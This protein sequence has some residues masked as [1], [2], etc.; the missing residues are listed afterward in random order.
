MVYNAPEVSSGD[1]SLL[2][3]GRQAGAGPHHIQG[4]FY[5]MSTVKITRTLIVMTLLAT[6]FITSVAAE[7]PGPPASGRR[8]VDTARLIGRLQ[9]ETED[10]ARIS[11]HGE[12]GKVRFIGT[13]LEHTITQPGRLSSAA[14]PEEAAR[15]FL[16]VYGPLFGLLDPSQELEVMRVEFRDRGRSFVRFQQVYRGIPVLGGELIVQMDAGKNVVSANGEVLPDLDLAVT[17]AISVQTARQTALAKAAKDHGLSA[18][19]LVASQPELWIYNPV[20]LGG[21]GLDLDRLVWRTEVTPLELAPIRELVLIDA[22]M[23]TVAL[24]FSQVETA[25]DRETYDAENG[26]TLPGTLICNESDPTCSVGDPHEQAA[27]RFV[28]ATY[29]YYANEHARDSIDDAGMT[30]VSTVHYKSGYENAFWNGEQMVYGDA[31]TYPMADDVVAHE[32]THGVTSH[33]SKLFYFYQSGSI[34]EAFSDIWGEFVDLEGSTGNDSGDTRWDI[35]ED[36]AS[37]GAI[38]SMKDPTIYNLPDRMT[39]SHYYCAQSDL[40]SGAGDNGGV[41]LNCGVGAKAAYLMTDGEAFNGY[42]VTGLGISKVADLWYEVQTNLLFSGADYADLYDALIQACTNLGYSSS[43][44][45]QVQKAVDATEMNQQ[46][47]QCPANEAPVCTIGT[48]SNLFFDNIESGGSNWTAGAIT[49]TPYWFVPQTSSTVGLA[50]PYATSGVGNIWGWGGPATSDTFLAMKNGVT[51]PA[52]AYLRF[53]H[54]FG[55]ESS[56]DLSGLYDGGIVEYSTNGGST[57]SDAGSLFDSNDYDYN[58]TLYSGNPLGAVAAFAGDSRG[59]IS[60]RLD[61]GSLQGQNVRFRF[62]IGTD[63]STYDYGWFIDDVHIYTCSTSAPLESVYLPLIARNY[64]PSPAPVPGTGIR[65]GDFESG[66]D[67]SWTESSYQGYSLILHS[68]TLPITPHSGSWATWLGGV[69]DE[70]SEISQSVTIPSGYSLLR[71]WHWIGSAD[72]CGY[73]WGMVY[74]DDD[75]RGR[76]DLC[77]DTGTGGWVIR[78]YDLSAYVGQTVVLQIRATTDGSLNSN[79]FIDDVALVPPLL[80]FDQGEDQAPDPTILSGRSDAERRMS[81]GR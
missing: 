42:N 19:E 68:S 36:L 66:A 73:D 28:G 75:E 24:A 3:I 77:S 72:V 39:S 32:Y 16:G 43:E 4:V 26:T 45:Q 27:H 55:F 13:D 59:Y 12:T 46:P 58:G 37:T 34:N 56:S 64:S 25:R 67:G 49:G 53:D 52:G 6:M 40:V 78:T 70:I 44:C 9:M 29:D 20:L 60:S 21:P 63:S 61:L 47:A 54:S 22:Q 51:L 30:L 35:G 2:W 15:Q 41:H 10:H 71:F 80:A 33:E 5:H 14:T 62:R 69:G 1:A 79:L 17:P 38:R 76:F 23:G 74:I 7:P 11:Y 18:G 50:E 65:N 57:W 8:G 31:D 81:P 48:P